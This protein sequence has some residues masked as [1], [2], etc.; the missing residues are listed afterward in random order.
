M[1]DRAYSRIL[2]VG[3]AISALTS[4]AF[5]QETTSGNPTTPAEAK[6]N[7]GLRD[8]IVTARRREEKLQSVPISAT[9]YDA[10]SLAQRNIQSTQDL[11]GQ[12]PSLVVG[13][14]GQQRS[15][16]NV[17]IRG[18]GS[19]FNA[20]PGVVLYFAEVPIIADQRNNAQNAG[21]ANYYDLASVQVLRGPQGTLF[22]RNT[23]G[24]ALVF[25]PQRPVD[26]YEG[27]AQFQYG[28]YNSVELRGALT[29]KIQRGLADV[30]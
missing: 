9:A 14:S 27:Y 28:N 20:A 17:T 4:P 23:T 24:G 29:R 1:K 19:T 21:G 25:E 5:A 8:I 3:V 10:Q 7:D 26:K 22:G 30:A 18:Q 16:E 13:G 12:V 15:S 11:F 6:Q 2:A